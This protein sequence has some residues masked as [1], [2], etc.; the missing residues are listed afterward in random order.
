[1]NQAIQDHR[2]FEMSKLKMNHEMRKEFEKKVADV[3]TKTNE[4]KL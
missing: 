3:V 4:V 1:M 2:Y